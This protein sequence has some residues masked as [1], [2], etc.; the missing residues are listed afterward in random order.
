MANAQQA[1]SAAGAA[2]E[3]FLGGVQAGTQFRRQRTLDRQVAEQIGVDRERQGVI[4]EQTAA[5]EL[6]EQQTHAIE[7]FNEGLRPISDEVQ[8]LRSEV[9]AVIGDAPPGFERFG[10]SPAQVE[11]TRL[12]ELRGRV[13]EFIADPAA[14]D[15]ADAANI[16]AL[17]ES[18]LLDDALRQR[19]AAA[20]P[21]PVSPL[22][23][24]TGRGGLE[25]TFDP[26]GDV[27][28]RVAPLLGPGGDQFRSRV[29]ADNFA[30]TNAQAAANAIS[31]LD[32]FDFA[33][34]QI[35]AAREQVA[36]RF[37]FSGVAQVE[38]TLREAVGGGEPGDTEDFGPL[39]EQAL[40]SDEL[41]DEEKAI[42]Q[43]IADDPT[44]AGQRAALLRQ[45]L[46]LD[47]TP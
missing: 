47:A 39:L 45:L 12:T 42:A 6:R 33:E 44:L 7:L 25:F 22:Q 30:R 15:L 37:G 32:P 20:R 5:E 38:Q 28:E 35:E 13:G 3:G 31:R 11:E 40:A 9:G 23:R 36:Q 16:E 10:P 1:G 29:P 4:D 46:G 19:E 27:G 41:S 14:F 17:E 26:R 8:G 34:G 43:E 2:I 18:G 24:V 21:D